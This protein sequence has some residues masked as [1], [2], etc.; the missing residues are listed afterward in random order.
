MAL[1]DRV[2]RAKFNLMYRGSQPHSTLFPEAF[3]HDRGFMFVQHRRGFSEGFKDWCDFRGVPNLFFAENPSAVRA[4]LE[5][6]RVARRAE[7]WAQFASMKSTSFA[8]SIFK[9]PG[10]LYSV[11]FEASK[12]CRLE[13]CVVLLSVTGTLSLSYCSSKCCTL[14]CSRFSFEHFLDC[15][16]LGPC[17]APTLLAYIDAKDWP[18]AARLL[19]SRFEVFIHAIRGGELSAEESEL[20]DSLVQ[21]VDSGDDV[22]GSVTQY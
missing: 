8:A 17:V 3:V 7:D 14:C 22:S 11:L 19:L 6:V 2:M 18:A 12:I 9:S 10:A 15:H 20:F 1:V 4:E 13:V 21:L 16:V 5:E